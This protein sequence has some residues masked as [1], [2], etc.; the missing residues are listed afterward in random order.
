MLSVPVVEV[1]SVMSV[2]SSVEIYASPYAEVTER[3][4]I[5]LFGLQ[6][7]AVSATFLLISNVVSRLLPKLKSVS[8]IFFLKSNDVS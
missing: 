4:A 5:V 7:K 1:A 2:A 3:V 6:D 8:A